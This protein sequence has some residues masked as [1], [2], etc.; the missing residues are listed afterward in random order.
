MYSYR[1][2][3][4]HDFI[5]IFLSPSQAAEKLVSICGALRTITLL[6]L[7]DT[8]RFQ[9]LTPPHINVL[10]CLLCIN[11]YTTICR[12]VYIVFSVGVVYIHSPCL[13][14]LCLTLLSA[15][16][17]TRITLIFEFLPFTPLRY[18]YNK[19]YFL[20][21]SRTFLSPQTVASTSQHARKP[22]HLALV[23]N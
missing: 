15:I 23:G 17:Y 14:I 4:P 16:S 12:C 19:A 20:P 3:L 21:R 9:G 10:K 22:I 1:F 2:C 18:E 13:Q 6:S 11:A 7:S 5:T 8:S